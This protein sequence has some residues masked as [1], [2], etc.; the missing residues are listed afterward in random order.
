CAD[1]DE[2]RRTLALLMRPREEGAVPAAMESRAIGAMRRALERE[3]IPRLSRRANRARPEASSAGLPI[4]AAVLVGLVALILT[5]RQ[6]A[7]HPP[8]QRELAQRP[9]P[10]E[11]APVFEPKPA[12]PSQAPKPAESP[13]SEPLEVPK[14]VPARPE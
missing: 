6:P 10:E 1:C 8:E 9:P 14:P 2:C 12:A 3:R 11:Q 4:A 7:V 5:A 13:K